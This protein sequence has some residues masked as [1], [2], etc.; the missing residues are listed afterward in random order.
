MIIA[1]TPSLKE[2]AQRSLHSPGGDKSNSA[3]R[4]VEPRIARHV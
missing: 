4:E 2:T 1:G 3:A